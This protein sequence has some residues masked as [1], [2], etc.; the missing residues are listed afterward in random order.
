M[1]SWPRSTD[2]ANNLRP[3]RSRDAPAPS[4][5]SSRDFAIA[6][7]FSSAHIDLQHIAC[8]AERQLQPRPKPISLFKLEK[9]GGT[10]MA[11][12]I[13]SSCIAHHCGLHKGCSFTFNAVWRACGSQ[14]LQRGP[15]NLVDAWQLCHP[16]R[17]TNASDGMTRAIRKCM[18]LPLLLNKA[19]LDL[20]EEHR[21][22][23]Y[24]APQPSLWQSGTLYTN[25]I[26]VFRQPVA[27]LMS[28]LYYFASHYRVS[29]MGGQLLR[30]I[31]VAN[32]TV[33]A[34]Q[35]L[36]DPSVQHPWDPPASV[37]RGLVAQLGGKGRAPGQAVERAAYL[38]D[39]YGLV[40]LTEQIMPTRA[41]I[42]LR[43]GLEPE[44]LVE[45]VRKRVGDAHH[46]GTLRPEVRA[47]A[48]AGLADELVLYERVLAIHSRQRAAHDEQ[49]FLDA[50]GRV[51]QAQTLFGNACASGCG[52][53][54]PTRD[55]ESNHPLHRHTSSTHA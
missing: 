25:F 18:S 3:C 41:L 39:R 15:D 50:I 53:T 29:A 30:E 13:A 8:M 5:L 46:S 24:I 16:P 28:G 10:T 37:L 32:L 51:Q 55:R 21:S 23:C 9:T 36:L 33:T 43:L 49:T 52:L 7:S 11:A 6:H 42:T 17:L 54:P 4:F 38:I 22:P 34:M 19:T 1:W 48:E 27:R 12:S 26:A 2:A 20:L 40:G 35:E 45:C 44:V 31:H 47:A 14:Q